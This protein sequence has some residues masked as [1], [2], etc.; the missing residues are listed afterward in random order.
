MVD[1][2]AFHQAFWECQ[3]WKA[4]RQSRWY[5]ASRPKESQSELL[6]SR[7]R[8]SQRKTSGQ[9][10]VEAVQAG[11]D[12]K[13]PKIPKITK[14]KLENQQRRWST[15]WTT[16]V[17]RQHMDPKMAGL[18][19]IYGNQRIDTLIWCLGMKWGT[20]P[21]FKFLDAARKPRGEP[22]GFTSMWS[23]SYSPS[24]S[25]STVDTWQ[26]RW[27]FLKSGIDLNLLP[28]RVSIIR[29]RCVMLQVTKNQGPIR[30]S[31]IEEIPKAFS[32]LWQA[33]RNASST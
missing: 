10:W 13:I 20:V 28:S 6:L 11:R 3:T 27:K 17:N 21:H 24:T 18:H 5:I 33:S 15:I 31:G 30:P 12:W 2:Q 9:N 23:A 29:V 14:K 4:A 32:F 7:C 8:C 26:M 25:I 19:P 16:C 1:H 22:F